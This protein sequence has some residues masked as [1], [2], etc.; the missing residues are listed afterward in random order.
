M[1]TKE[2]LQKLHDVF[3]P[4]VEETQ[5]SEIE[6]SEV[7]VEVQEEEVQDEVKEVELADAPMEE[8]AP[9]EEVSAEPKVEYV[10]KL[11]LEEMKRTFMDL[12]AALQKETE[13][14][15]EVPQ[16]LS[17]DE[18]ELAEEADEIPHSPELEVAKKVDL[19]TPKATKNQSIQSRVYEKLFN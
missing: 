6:L 8:E 11:E 17:K 10:T 19:Y 15:Q 2:I 5:L 18:V 1:N 13:T 4:K 12:L 7:E 14:K 3:V 16:E 9:K